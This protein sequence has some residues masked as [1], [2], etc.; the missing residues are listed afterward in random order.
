MVMPEI[1]T[2]KNLS[3]P[4]EILELGD[5]GTKELMINEY[6]VGRMLIHP[7]PGGQP[8]EIIALRVWVPDTIKTLYPDYYD[9]T[10][11]TL[12]AQ[13]LPT[14]EA[15]DFELK[16]FTI[17]KFGTGPSARFSVSVTS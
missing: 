4:F 8:K 3:G 16:R 13:L 2:L 14:L 17:Q 15:G 10:S 7:R 11:Q 5:R 6:K 9:I 12:I 1:G